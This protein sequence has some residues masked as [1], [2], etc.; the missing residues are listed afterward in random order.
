MTIFTNIIYDIGVTSLAVYTSAFIVYVNVSKSSGILSVS[1]D[2]VYIASIFLLYVKILKSTFW[3][4]YVS[5]I[6]SAGTLSFSYLTY[7]PFLIR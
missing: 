4:T 3:P 2:N 6:L 5:F 1:K 7:A